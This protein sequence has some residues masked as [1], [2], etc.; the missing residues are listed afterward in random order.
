MILFS[1]KSIIALGILINSG[2]CNIHSSTQ[3]WILNDIISG[4]LSLTLFDN[5]F[6]VAVNNNSNLLFHHSILQS[7]DNIWLLTIVF[8]AF[9]VSFH[10]D[11]WASSLITSSIKFENSWNNSK[12]SFFNLARA[13][14][15]HIITGSEI[16]FSLIL[17]KIDLIL[18][19]IVQF[20]HTIKVFSLSKYSSV[21]FINQVFGTNIT[22]FNLIH[23][24]ISANNLV[25]YN[26]VG[27]LINH[28]V[29]HFKR[30]SIVAI[31]DAVC[32]FLKW[33]ES[34]SKSINERI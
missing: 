2:I 23:S 6:G 20:S 22:V 32:H 16:C 15:V 12:L 24:I 27:N 3:S 1:H 34:F 14:Y 13:W 9:D 29:F 8:N 33:S 30:R 19:T 11:L 10:N 5:K 25:F 28:D 17:S 18:C 31:I 21:C 7:F 4:Y 26:H